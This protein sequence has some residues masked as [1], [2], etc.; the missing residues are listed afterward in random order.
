MIIRKCSQGHRIRIHRNNTKGT[1]RTKT[2]SDGTVES[3][4]YPSSYNYFIDVD[5]KI[6]KKSN[7]FKVIEEFYVD[8]CAKKHSEGHGRV[9]IGKHKLVNGVITEL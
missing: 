8:E 3:L 9:I 2:Y 5:G 7:S 1:T 6:I 4:T